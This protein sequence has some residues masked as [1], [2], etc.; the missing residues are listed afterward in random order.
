MA[1]LDRQLI[2]QHQVLHPEYSPALD[3]RARADTTAQLDADSG[4]IEYSR[5]DIPWKEHEWN[6]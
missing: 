3:Q 5:D 6:T 1:A 4:G 2:F